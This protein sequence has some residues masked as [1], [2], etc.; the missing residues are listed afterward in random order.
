LNVLDRIV[1]S[2]HASRGLAHKRDIAS[3]LPH[4]LPPGVNHDTQ[5]G[6][7]LVGDDCAA[8]PDRDGWLLFA[9]EGF[10]NEFVQA[11]PFFA[12]YCG[13]MVN[14]SDIF[15]MGGRP[16]AVVDALWSRDH[17]HARPILDG[18]RTA[19]HIYGT[20][21]VGG[22][23]NTRN[24]REQLSVAVL[25]RA[26]RLMTSFGARPGDVLVI[27]VDLRGRYREPFSN[28]DASTGAE[29]SR[30][31]AD[32]DLLPGIAEDGLCSAAKDISQAGV[33][34]TTMMLLECSGVGGFIDVNA[35][36][37]PAHVAAERWLISTFPSYGFVLAVAE[38]SLKAVCDRFDARGIAC[39][40][41]GRCDDSGI[42]RL[43]EGVNERIAWDFRQQELIGCGPRLSRRT[44]TAHA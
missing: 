10:L 14:V 27:A 13:V 12:G 35:V 28:W 18:L 29:G 44:E 32:L 42:V 2:L 16:L 21:I 3:V 36:P 17:Q 24:D 37:R 22:H 15:A 25:G 41:V 40:P 26:S 30:L 19:A 34:G 23:S 33:I 4:L 1:T 31:R 39:A 5:V 9:I 38:P 8:L 43:R 7:V 20:P 6:S 11:D